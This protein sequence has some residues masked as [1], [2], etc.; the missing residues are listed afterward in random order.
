MSLMA[1][2]GRCALGAE[3][4]PGRELVLGFKLKAIADEPRVRAET[5]RCLAD[6]TLASSFRGS[7]QARRC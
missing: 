2:R 7:G 3:A 5:V 1:W 6:Q 4:E